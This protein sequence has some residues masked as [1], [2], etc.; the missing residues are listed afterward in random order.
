M[1]SKAFILR[2][3]M[4]VGLA[5]IVL[6]PLLHTVTT[7]DR[8]SSTHT[9]YGVTA[10]L[11]HGIVWYCYEASVTEGGTIEIGRVI[12]ITTNEDYPVIGL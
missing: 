4:M 5:T 1:A 12:V 11:N 3:G 2:M 7:V 10:S 9:K 6:L 8:D